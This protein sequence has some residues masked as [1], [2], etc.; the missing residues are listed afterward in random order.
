M[1]HM[2]GTNC[3]C[4]PFSGN[5]VSCCNGNNKCSHLSS[6]LT[7]SGNTPVCCNSDFDSHCCPP[8]SACSQGCRDT[9][10]GG[11]SCIP[12]RHSGYTEQDALFALGFVAASQCDPAKGLNDTWSCTAC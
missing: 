12:L 9:L 2:H 5:P 4:S 3:T 8:A 11:C 1:A 10:L 7:C 6:S